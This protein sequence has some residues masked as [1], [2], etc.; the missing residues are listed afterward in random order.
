M[1]FFY[2]CVIHSEV[3][4]SCADSYM[5]LVIEKFGSKFL[6]HQFTLNLDQIILILLG[7]GRGDSSCHGVDGVLRFV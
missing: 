6:I 4:H 1:F 5:F 3:T 2:L 7:I